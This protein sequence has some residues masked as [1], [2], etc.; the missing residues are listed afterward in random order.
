VFL[1]S[2]GRLA[3]SRE[4]QDLAVIIFMESNDFH[5]MATARHDNPVNSRAHNPSDFSPRRRG[6]F[7]TD[8][9]DPALTSCSSLI[10]LKLCRLELRY[11]LRSFLHS[12]KI[13]LLAYNSAAY[14]RVYL[15]V[16]P[17]S[18][19]LQGGIPPM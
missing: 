15:L 5:F 19:E 18:D 2:V 8:P 1:S 12:Q 16:D 17:R 10:S 4:I 7:D 14:S 3:L 9:D 13:H 11:P 6:V